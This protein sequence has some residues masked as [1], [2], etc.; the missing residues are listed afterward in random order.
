MRQVQYLALL[1]DVSQFDIEDI[2]GSCISQIH[3]PYITGDIINLLFMKG[4]SKYQYPN[5]KKK[6]KSKSLKVCILDLRQ[7][8]LIHLSRIV[9]PSTGHHVN[10]IRV[11]P[12]N[13]GVPQL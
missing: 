9:L 2:S 11:I 4:N 1:K 10:D 13:R 8:L 5:S 6:L 12:R 3:T 7:P